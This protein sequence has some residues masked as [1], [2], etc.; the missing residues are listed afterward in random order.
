MAE[1]RWNQSNFSAGQ[2]DP[3]AFA[4]DDIAKYYQGA[5]I[6]TNG[7]VLP[8]GGVQTRWGTDFVD[9]ITTTNPVNTQIN[10]LVYDDTA[11]YLLLWEAGSIKIYLE[12]ML[13]A[14][15]TDNVGYAAEDIQNL[16]FCQVLNNLIIANPAFS[17]CQLVRTNA[18]PD[19]IL[20]ISA[21]AFTFATPLTAHTIYP[22]QFTG[23]P[24]MTTSPQIFAGRTYYIRTSTT[25]TAKIY[26]TPDDAYNQVNSFTITA[27]GTSPKLIVQNTWTFSTI[28]LISVPVYD[29]SDQESYA[30]VTFTIQATSSP[31]TSLGA[32]V[33]IN[34]G[35]AF[36]P[37]ID[38][39]YV[40]GQL[41]GNGYTLQIQ[42]PFMAPST[43]ATATI[44]G[45]TN[46]I[47]G[48]NPFDVIT[49]M[50][51]GVAYLAAPAWSD[52][53]GWPRAVSYYQG[54]LVLAG[55]ASLN[56]GV[57][58]SAINEVFNFGGDGNVA[59]DN[60]IS[61]Y[62]ASGGPAY[63]RS[64]TSARTLLI[65]TNSGTY[66]TNTD[67][68][69]PLTPSNFFL[70]E[71]NKDGVSPIQPV[72]ID[73][74][75]IYVDRSGNNAKNLIFDI[76]QGAYLLNNISVLS[77]NC[78][79][80]PIDVAALTEPNFTDGAYVLFVNADGTLGVFQ[81]LIAQGI[82]AWSTAQT[83]N[84]DGSR[85]PYAHVA[86][87]L[88]DCWFIVQ[89]TIEAVPTLF[90]ERINFTTHMDATK[91]YPG[92]NSATVTGLD[93]L[94]GQTVY[95]IAD[96]FLQNP[97][98]VTGGQITLPATAIN[99]SVGLGF[100]TTLT[101]LP[102]GG[103]PQTNAN[104]YKPMH[105]RTIYVNYYNTIGGT[106]ANSQIETESLEMILLDQPP[107]PQSG[108]KE[109]KLMGGWNTIDYEISIQQTQPLPM[110]IIGVGYILE[111]P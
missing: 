86:S 72:F 38:M 1:L 50:L 65:H 18:T 67:S 43:L 46:P 105:I 66:S 82:A 97:L 44:I 69:T 58:L 73:N 25:T 99:V 48:T 6:I 30:T 91:Y 54:R 81:T 14:T 40:G 19:D 51:P 8:Q 45:N 71:Q 76:I 28:T 29:F 49:R 70:A 32:V 5:K 107:V 79:V 55:T 96:G 7:V 87:S 33:T 31:D 63:V 89:R 106:V 102:I 17:P 2:F 13:V 9:T 85:A 84:S 93:Y 24:L 26:A 16:Y 83:M 10:T 103:I 23:S 41:S 52:T 36:N 21:N 100:T 57:W 39:S 12:D 47:I 34:A 109:L 27:L 90:I 11:I 61:Y 64:I 101:L 53:K 62:A 77:S 88:N 111:I 92:L 110:T 68:S 95:A 108:I 37:T 22:A 78:I 35:S 60:P 104:L 20:S 94:E 56:N 4:R 75:V 98:V 59:D 42:T 80:N 15:V 74:Q 3:R